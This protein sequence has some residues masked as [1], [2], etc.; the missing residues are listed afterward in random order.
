MSELAGSRIFE[1]AIAEKGLNEAAFCYGK[2]SMIFN[3]Q[4]TII[5]LFYLGV[6]M[7]KTLI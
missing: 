1:F 6:N 3:V 5:H 7:K 4:N 2:E